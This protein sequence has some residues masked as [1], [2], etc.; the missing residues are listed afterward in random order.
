MREVE[1]YRRFRCVRSV[2]AV[3]HLMI[4]L[5]QTSEHYPDTRQSIP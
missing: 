2:R 5:T 3:H 1:A 4:L